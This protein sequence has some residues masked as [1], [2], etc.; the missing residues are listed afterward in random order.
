MPF[1][2]LGWL[3]KINMV[4]RLKVFGLPRSGTNLLELLLPLNFDVYFCG[5]REFNDHL[6]WKHA[7]PLPYPDYEALG[8]ALGESY[9]FIFSIRDK[10]EWISAMEKHA[11]SFEMPRD[12]RSADCLIWNTPMGPEIYSD[13]AHYYRS[14][15]SAYREFCVANP[16]RALLVNY[17]AFKGNQAILLN[18]IESYFSFP[19]IQDTWITITSQIDWHG[20]PSGRPC[21]L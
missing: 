3:S 11:G 2:T 5:R 18:Q 17:S 1:W 6:G 16:G 10:C 14:Q 9:Y 7:R 20:R 4:P 15:T 8:R 21:N 19:K 13:L 12:F